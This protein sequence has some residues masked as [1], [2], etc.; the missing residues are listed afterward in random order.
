MKRVLR[1]AVGLVAIALPCAAPSC[2][3]APPPAA[4]TPELAPSSL[5]ASSPA[6]LEVLRR[7]P[8]LPADQTVDVAGLQVLAAAPYSTASGRVCRALRLGDE[9]RLACSGEQGWV[10]V[11][12]L[13]EGL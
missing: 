12:V 3:S 8:E 9:P 13:I 4:W 11:P 1:L 6:E 2:A 5:S 10:F 7:A